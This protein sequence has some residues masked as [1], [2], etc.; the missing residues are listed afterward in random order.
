MVSSAMADI[1]STVNRATA[2]IAQAVT[3]AENQI[4]N[5]VEDALSQIPDAENLATKVYVQEQLENVQV[6]LTGYATETW[7]QNKISDATASI[8]TDIW[9]YGSSAPSNKKLLWIDSN[10]STGGLKF[11]KSSSEGW[12]HV[13]VAWQ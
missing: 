13:P 11:Y 8:V 4:D 3:A 5:K 10:T 12:V 7:V 6:D 9:Y 2:T 1:N